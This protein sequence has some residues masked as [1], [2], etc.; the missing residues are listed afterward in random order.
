MFTFCLSL[1]CVV[2]I[3]EEQE[4]EKDKRLVSNFPDFKVLGVEV[5]SAWLRHA[6]SF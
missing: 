2:W 5:V 6:T 3:K 4:A 1:W